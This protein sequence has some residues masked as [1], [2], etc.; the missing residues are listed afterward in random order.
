MKELIDA[1]ELGKVFYAYANR[2]NLGKVRTDENAL[3]SFG[4]ARHLGAQLPHR[5]R[6]GGGQRPR[7]VLPAGRRRGR[8]LRL[9]QVQERRRR[10]P[11]RELAGPAQEPQDHR[12]RREEDGRL[13]RHGV[14]AQDHRLRQGR[15]HDAHQVRDL[16]R[17]RHPALRR[18]PHPQDRQRR[19]AAPRDVS[20]SSTA[21][22]RRAAAQRRPRRAQRR[23]GARRHG[24]QPARGRPAGEDRGAVTV[25]LHASGLG[26]NL[27]LG[28]GVVVGADV[29][30]GA[31]V[32]VYE[33]TVIGD[34]C[35]IQDGAVLGKVPSL[36]PTSTAKRGELRAARARR[37]LRD[38]H[39]RR[40]LPRHHA[41]PRLHPRRLRRRARALHPGRAGRRRAQQRGGE[42]HDD[43]RLHQDPDQRVH[44]RVH[45][46]RG[47]LLHR[48]LR[49]DHERQLHGAHREAARAHQGRDHP[50][51]RPRRRRRGAVPGHRDRRGGL[52]RRR[53]RGHQGRAGPQGAHGRAGARRARRLR[54]RAAREPVAATLGRGSRR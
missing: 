46:H 24:D 51:R 29:V 7:R 16:R 26:H 48:P 41:R 22:R 14:R 33:D 35:F 45:D 37:R 13:R 32:V 6:A 21:S 43:R 19:A 40:G 54:G 42:R 53:R 23:Q 8:G 52:H 11:A 17:V 50:P 5:R 31:N 34:G 44:H 2:L 38:Q 10:P 28:D 27:L 15:H 25:G 4:A 12:G 9:H 39:R 20:T 3:W 36:S 49:A 47:P 1:G 30:F 18:H